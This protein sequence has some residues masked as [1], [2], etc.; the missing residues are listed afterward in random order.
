MLDEE[1]DHGK[2]LKERGAL[3][4]ARLPVKIMPS[5]GPLPRKPAWIR[6]KAPTAPEVQRL[7]ALLRRQRL[8]TVC[9]EASCPNLGECFSQ[10]TATFMIMGDVCTRRCPFCDVAH[11]RPEPLDPEEPGHL[12]ETVALLGLRYVV[13]TSVD[14][15]DLRDG[16]AAHFVACIQALRAVCPNTRVEILVPDFRGRMDVALETLVGAPPDVFNHNLESVPRLYRQVRPGA[17]YAWS[18]RLLQAFKRRRPAVLTKSGLMLGLGETTAEVQAVMRDL[19]GH[20][21]DMITL[22]QYLQPS[23]HHLPVARFVAPEEF[24]TL[25]AYAR[26]LGFKNVASGPL[27]RSSYHADR[28]AA[29]EEVG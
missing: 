26:D 28:Q 22:G 6:V 9:E 17:D 4:T 20:E 2:R 5:T 21:C 29:G 3:K 19:R 11:G 10:G 27:V 13:V 18:L 12:A 7:K 1:K 25:G 8:H 15:D 14:R 24:E 16:G 23:R